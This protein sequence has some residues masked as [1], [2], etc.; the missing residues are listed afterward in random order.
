MA[1]FQSRDMKASLLLTKIVADAAQ[2]S[3]DASIA[4]MRA[5]IDL[6][7]PIIHGFDQEGDSRVDIFFANSGGTVAFEVVGESGVTIREA[8]ISRFKGDLRPD[9]YTLDHRS[10]AAL[11][12]NGIF[13]GSNIIPAVHL[14]QDAKAA[15]RN[16]SHAIFVYGTVTYKDSL[17]NPH[18]T[19]YRL[20]YGGAPGAHPEGKFVICKKEMIPINASAPPCRRRE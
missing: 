17:K 6:R 10:K 12:R 2:K 7:S 5:Y 14:S 20:M 8:E 15:I 16:G 9:N 19:T 11:P 18:T 4:Q 3:A 1:I 13:G